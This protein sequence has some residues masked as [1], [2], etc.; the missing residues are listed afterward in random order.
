PSVNRP[1]RE[2]IGASSIQWARASPSSQSGGSSEPGGNLGSAWLIRSARVPSRTFRAV[3]LGG[4]PLLTSI[5][6]RPTARDFEFC[7]D[8][9]AGP[10]AAW[11]LKVSAESPPYP[12]K[13]ASKGLP[14]PP[15][16]VVARHRVEHGSGPPARQVAGDV[17]GDVAALV[18]VAQ[19]HLER[20]VP[21]ELPHV[22]HFPARV[23]R[24]LRRTVPPPVGAQGRRQ[25]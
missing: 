25:P 2:S 22:A 15:G 7:H 17:A 8:A 1:R 20:L 3:G 19:D 4:L 6:S 14:S 10:V 23:Q 21:G 13:R 11:A 12:S 24:R 9:R 18:V 16:A 5:P